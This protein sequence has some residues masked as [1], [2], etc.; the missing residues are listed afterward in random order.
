MFQ[1]PIELQYLIFCYDRT[2]YDVFEKCLTDIRNSLIVEYN[3][4][5]KR[6]PNKNSLIEI[7]QFVKI[8]HKKYSDDM[9]KAYIRDRNIYNFLVNHY[10]NV[11]Y[12]EFRNFYDWFY[13]NKN[14]ID[15]IV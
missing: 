2:Y 13:K 10:Y 8:E 11:E 12:N 5:F 6:T 4:D 1:L 14:S 3:K 15:N 7:Y 9:M